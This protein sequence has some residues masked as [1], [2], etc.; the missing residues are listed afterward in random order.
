MHDVAGPSEWWLRPSGY[1]FWALGNRTPGQHHRRAVDRLAVTLGRISPAS[2]LERTVPVLSITDLIEPMWTRGVTRPGDSRLGPWLTAVYEEIDGATW[3]RAGACV[4]T[5]IGADG[6]VRYVGC[7]KNRLT[8]RWRLC[9]AYEPGTTRPMIKRLF[10]NRCFPEITDEF[11][12][13]TDACFEV[14]VASA[15]GLSDLLEGADTPEQTVYAVERELRNIRT[16]AFA[17]WNRV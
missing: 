1:A 13:T 5:V 10:H 6:G 14:R 16:L 4:Y 2:F 9:P 12:N 11:A 8:A 15:E 17:P 3:R 7:T